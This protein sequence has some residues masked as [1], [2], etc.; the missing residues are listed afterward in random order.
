MNGGRLQLDTPRADWLSSYAQA[1]EKGWSPDN[2]RD[3]S[4]EQLAALKRDPSAFIASLVAQ[5][6]VITLPD[7]STRPKIPFTRLW[8]WDGEFC[9]TIALRWQEGTDLLP[10]HV[11]GHIGYA[12]VPWKRGRGY[13]SE[14]LRVILERARAVGLARVEIT[15]DPENEASRRVI[16]KNG[17]RF[18]E[19]FVNEAYGP[20]MRLRYAVELKDAK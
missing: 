8:L 20:G 14:A 18:V 15:T 7:G 13:A 17:G 16:E 4:A 11:L 3:V 10:P 12:I 2:T 5:G 19:E 6:G 9:G 1:L